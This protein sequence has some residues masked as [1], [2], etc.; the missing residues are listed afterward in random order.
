MRKTIAQFQVPYLQILNE[1]GDVDEKLMPSLQKKKVKE[2]FELMILTRVFDDIALRMNREGRL[3]TY[4]PMIGEEASIVGTGYAM[5]K[6]DWLVPSF[7]ENTTKFMKG[8]PFDRL[9]LYWKG[10]SRG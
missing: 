6:K 4:A 8:V 9:L 10:D 3:G 2:L 7:R 5:D 1:K